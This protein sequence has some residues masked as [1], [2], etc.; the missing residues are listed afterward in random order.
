MRSTGDPVN[1]RACKYFINV[2]MMF[3]D[4]KAMLNAVAVEELENLMFVLLVRML[5]QDVQNIMA[6]TPVVRALNVLMMK[7]LS[8]KFG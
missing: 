8:D 4:V 2:I 6:G 1:P 3:T 7:I 5:D